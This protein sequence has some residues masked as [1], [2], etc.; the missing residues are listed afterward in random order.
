MLSMTSSSLSSFRPKSFAVNLQLY[1]DGV[2][3]MLSLRMTV[4]VAFLAVLLLLRTL[5]PLSVIGLGWDKSRS[6]KD[7]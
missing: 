5:R 2:Y 7:N 3:R 4:S 1:S 6:L